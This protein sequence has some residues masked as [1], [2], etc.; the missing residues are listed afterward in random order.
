MGRLGS[1]AYMHCYG[2][3]KGNSAS[4]QG[5]QNGIHRAAASARAAMEWKDVKFEQVQSSAELLAYDKAIR[6][7]LA[8][9]Q[10]M[11][12]PWARATGGK[13]GHHKGRNRQLQ[14]QAKKC[15]NKAIL[16]GAQQIA[17]A[18]SAIDGSHKR[19]LKSF[20]EEIAAMEKMRASIVYQLPALG[21][22]EELKRREE[23][24]KRLEEEKKKKKEQPEEAPVL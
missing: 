19:Q 18:V 7:S 20:Q 9:Y 12:L 8:L 5:L 10:D 11:I 22:G 15:D 1:L 14:E 17:S 23:E 16:S 4:L 2:L 24:K 13:M 3:L 21:A 6:R